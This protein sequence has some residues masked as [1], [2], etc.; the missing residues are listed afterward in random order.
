MTVQIGSMI[1]SWRAI[2]PEIAYKFV[3]G[4][5]CDTSNTFISQIAGSQGSKNPHKQWIKITWKHWEISFTVSLQSSWCT[6][7]RE[8]VRRTEES[9]A[10]KGPI[11]FTTFVYYS[12]ICVF[13]SMIIATCSCHLKVLCFVIRRFKLSVLYDVYRVCFKPVEAILHFTNIPY[14]DWT[15]HFISFGGLIW[16]MSNWNVLISIDRAHAWTS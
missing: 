13:A 14:S 12:C 9:V 4:L 6:L 3:R 10:Y 5:K 7:L 2:E 11:N 16:K 8:F 1:I 15:R